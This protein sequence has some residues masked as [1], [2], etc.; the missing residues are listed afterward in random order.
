MI[1][2]QDLPYKHCESCPEFIL[3]LHEETMFAEDGIMTRKL[4]VSC[5]NEPLCRRLENARRESRVHGRE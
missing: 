4:E 3:S 2:E 1:I 5:K